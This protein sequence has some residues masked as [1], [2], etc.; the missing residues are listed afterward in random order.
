MGPLTIS[1]ISTTTSLYFRPL[2]AI[3]DGLV[4][5][6]STRPMAWA[7]RI[8]PTSPVSMKNFIGGLPRAVLGNGLELTWYVFGRR[9]FRSGKLSTQLGAR[10]RQLLEPLAGT[11]R[12]V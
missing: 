10:A 7:S 2:L 9:R 6:P 1:Q 4:V 8:S 11:R 5:T 3:S 12:F